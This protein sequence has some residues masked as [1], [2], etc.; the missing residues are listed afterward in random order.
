[1]EGTEGTNQDV[2]VQDVL[3]D[4]MTRLTFEGRGILGPIWTPDGRFIVYQDP[5]GAS[6]TRADGGGK[7]QS[8]FRAKNTV[9]PW[10]FTPD[11]RKLV[12]MEISSGTYDLWSVPIEEQDGKLRAGAPEVI[13]QTPFDERYPAI[14]PDGRWLAY[15]SNESGKYEIYVRAFPETASGGGKWEISNG[16]GTYPMWSRAGRELYFESLDARI[17]VAA[18]TASGG[19]FAAQKPRVWSEKQLSNL[20][21][22]SKNLDIAPDGKRFAVILPAEQPGPASS[23]SRIRMIE[24]FAEE[25]RRRVRAGK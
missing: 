18:Y 19:S 21:T 8:L 23:G 1:M 14:S 5:Q 15:T 20:V 17:L 9:F 12:Y 2:W 7:S 24:N 6:W 3:R 4:S 22:V 16:G 10:S 25:L 11:G 13:L